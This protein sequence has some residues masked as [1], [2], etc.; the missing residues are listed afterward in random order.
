[1]AFPLPLPPALAPTLSPLAPLSCA[2]NGDAINRA[3]YFSFSS[4]SAFDVA[5]LLQLSPLHPELP[6]PAHPL[7]TSLVDLQPLAL[8]HAPL[9]LASA[10][11]IAHRDEDVGN[12]MGRVVTCRLLAGG[13][14]PLGNGLEGPA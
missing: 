11:D 3:G 1:M 12:R 6:P 14:E 13:S 5:S 8:A 4:D 9:P 7:P 2:T 10:A